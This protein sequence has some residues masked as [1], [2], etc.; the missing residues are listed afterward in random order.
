MAKRQSAK[1]RPAKKSKKRLGIAYPVIF[2]ILLC[3]GVYLA[4]MTFGVKAADIAVTARIDGEPVTSPAVITSPAEGTHF[5][6]VPITV[7][8]TCP[9][10][11]AY[12]KIFRNSVMAG[13]AICQLDNTFSLQIS[14][15][16][17]ANTLI[18]HVF[19]ITDDE[20]PASAPIHVVYDVPVPPTPPASGGGSSGSPSSGGSTGGSGSSANPFVITTPFIYKGYYIN[21]TVEWPVEISGGT[22]PYAFNINWGDGDNSVISRKNA[23]GF[24]ITHKYTK[25]GG[26]KGSYN[27]T[28]QASDSEGNYAYMQFFV[29]V[30]DKNDNRVTGTGNIY[31]KPPP[32]LDNLRSWLKIAWPMY[33][34]LM[35]MAI[36]FKLGEKEELEIIKRKG[37]P[38]RHA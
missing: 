34:A 17:G 23:D 12:V 13:S 2:F 36:C 9:A 33:L 20:G 28:I 22:A 31:N 37:L 16:P 30:S 3:V 8:G 38:R 21:D 24:N 26:Y 19:N 11:A 10:N 25:A 18:A 14:L 1:R 7:T 5:T 32:T 4:L 15:V 27:I 35:I 29:I 6:A